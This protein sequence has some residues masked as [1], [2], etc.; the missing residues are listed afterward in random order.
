MKFPPIDLTRAV[1]YPLTQRK[2]QVAASALGVPWRI[3][4]SIRD[5][6][7]SLPRLLAAADLRE[8]TQRIVAA[9]R[10]QRPVVLG[11]G[12]HPLKV[13]LSPLIIDLLERGL[14]QI[15]Q[16]HRAAPT[17]KLVA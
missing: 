6:L 2:S 4:G 13:G 9:V 16:P 5:F 15:G 11:M 8:V 1:T 14:P 17:K 10:A 12:A 7:N 3:G